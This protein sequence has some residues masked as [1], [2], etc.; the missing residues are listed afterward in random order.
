MRGP[1]P[2]PSQVRPRRWDTAGGHRSLPGAARVRPPARP[3]PAPS[4]VLSD[5]PSA[6]SPLGPLRAPGPFFSVPLPVKE[7]PLPAR[8][9]PSTWTPLGLAAPSAAGRSFPSHLPAPCRCPVSP[10]S[11]PMPLL[12]PRA[13]AGIGTQGWRWAG[14]SPRTQPRSC[15]EFS[16]E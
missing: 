3:F 13:P 8:R 7:P 12:A 11:V 5:T 14:L 15:S 2:A 6:R 16:P 1:C 9:G 10:A 4:E